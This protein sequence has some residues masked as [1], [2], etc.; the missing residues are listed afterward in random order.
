MGPPRASP[1]TGGAQAP[2]G[3][4]M[5]PPGTPR[6]KRQPFGPRGPLPFLPATDAGRLPGAPGIFGAPLVLPTFLSQTTWRPGWGRPGPLR[7]PGGCRH[8][9]GPSRGPPAPHLRSVNLLAPGG[10]CPSCQ[11]LTQ[12]AN[13]PLR[14]PHRGGH[15]PVWPATGTRAQ[16]ASSGP[17]RPAEGPRG[18][19]RGGLAPRRHAMGPRSSG[20]GRRA[21]GSL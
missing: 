15:F 21:R 1:T 13:G 5:G 18:R 14:T 10:L 11:P 4:L 16:I 8:P 20:H 19:Q 9:G 2:G 6:P 12:G 17:R 3:P 7:P